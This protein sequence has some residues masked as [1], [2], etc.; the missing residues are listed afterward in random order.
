MNVLIG[1]I[2]GIIIGLQI[3]IGFTIHRLFR[4]QKRLKELED[5]YY[6]DFGDI[7]DDILEIKDDLSDIYEKL[8]QTDKNIIE[9]MYKNV[10]IHEGSIK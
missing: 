3:V 7:Q 9:I 8:Q 2:I 1:A 5:N 6:S 4:L 10:K